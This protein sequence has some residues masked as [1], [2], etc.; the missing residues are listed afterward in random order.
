M[1]DL[2]ND[3]ALD[4]DAYNLFTAPEEDV[5]VIDMVPVVEFKPTGI[6]DPITLETKAVALTST[7]GEIMGKIKVPHLPDCIIS[8]DKYFSASLSM[9]PG[10]SSFQFRRGEKAINNTTTVEMTELGFDTL[11]LH[12]P[13]FMEYIINLEDVRQRAEQMITPLPKEPDIPKTVILETMTDAL[14]NKISDIQMQI[15]RFPNSLSCGVTIKQTSKGGD[16]GRSVCITGSS[17]VLFQKSIVPFITMMY[18]EF[19]QFIGNVMEKA[20]AA[21]TGQKVIVGAWKN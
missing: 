3:N 10:R 5:P 6:L 2:M 14:G 21:S 8:G 16:N 9:Q 20:G 15:Y 11:L 4:Q 7:V 17:F 18:K 13:A 19:T 12:A 1:S